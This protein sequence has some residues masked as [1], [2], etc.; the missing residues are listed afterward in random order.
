M[1]VFNEM[2][3]FGLDKRFCWDFWGFQGIWV[4]VGASR[5]DQSL[6]LSGFAPAFGRAVGR[7]AAGIPHG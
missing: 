2:Y 4:E 3:D 7:F 5:I 1:L 6:A